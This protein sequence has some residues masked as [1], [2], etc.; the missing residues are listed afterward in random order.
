LSPAPL[1]GK[2]GR[3]LRRLRIARPIT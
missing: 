3:A 2:L 1:C